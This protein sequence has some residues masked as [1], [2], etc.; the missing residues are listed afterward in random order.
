MPGQHPRL[1]WSRSVKEKRLAALHELLRIKRALAGQN[2]QVMRKPQ[3]TTSNK[4]ENTGTGA[5]RA[6]GS[7]GGST[8]KEEVSA[9][10]EKNKTKEYTGEG[11]KRRKGKPK[12]PRI[13]HHGILSYCYVSN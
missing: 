12:P 1:R 6:R 3:T 9:T 11:S 2:T 13:K 7:S 4:N 5:N 10:N 8:A